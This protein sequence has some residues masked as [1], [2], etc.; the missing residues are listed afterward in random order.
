[1]ATLAKGSRKVI[2]A[3]VCSKCKEKRILTLELYVEGAVNVFLHEKDKA[4]EARE[5]ALEQAMKDIVSC[6]KMPRMLGSHT[7][8]DT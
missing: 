6:Y 3:Y 2:A 5:M 8:I 7:M 4:E 1:M